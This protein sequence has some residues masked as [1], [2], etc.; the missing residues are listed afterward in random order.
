MEIQSKTLVALEY[1][2]I[3]QK[4]A[5]ERGVTVAA[6]DSEIERVILTRLAYVPRSAKLSLLVANSVILEKFSVEGKLRDRI[7]H[8]L[9]FFFKINVAVKHRNVLKHSHIHHIC[10]EIDS[11]DKIA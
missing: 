10:R 6:R 8:L 7:L 4:L 11:A 2:K 9:C 5:V 3:L 1:D